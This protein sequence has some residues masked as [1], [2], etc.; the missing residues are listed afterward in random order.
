LKGALDAIRDLVVGNDE[1]NYQV[2]F[3]IPPKKRSGLLGWL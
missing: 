1:R 3:T 2:S